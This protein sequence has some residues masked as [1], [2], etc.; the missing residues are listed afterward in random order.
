MRINAGYRERNKPSVYFLVGPVFDIEID[1]KETFDGEEI[2]TPDDIYEGLEIG[3]MFGAG[4]EVARIGIEGR[5]SWGFK[6]VLA[7]DDAL[8]N[9]FGSTKLNTFSVIAK[10]R[11]N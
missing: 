2:D 11:F 6:S 8:E 1:T 4:F 5:Y 7:T 9:A 10:I 3:L